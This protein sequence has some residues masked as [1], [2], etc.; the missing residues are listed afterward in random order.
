M[1]KPYLCEQ[2]GG[3]HPTLFCPQNYS[4]VTY[5]CPDCGY[6]YVG[7]MLKTAIEHHVL[8]ANEKG[9]YPMTCNTCSNCKGW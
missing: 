1:S 8:K 4:D 5:Y 7:R 2:C 9:Q 3:E 6:T